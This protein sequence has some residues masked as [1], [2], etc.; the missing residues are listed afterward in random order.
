MDGMKNTIISDTSQTQKN[1]IM[2]YIHLYEDISC[3]VNVI[4]NLK[5]IQQKKLGIE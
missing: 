2:I 1:T 5:P 4:T 3:W